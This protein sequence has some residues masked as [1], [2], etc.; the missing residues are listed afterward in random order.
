ME[1]RDGTEAVAGA[2]IDT[3]GTFAAGV[4][5]DT[6]VDIYVDDQLIDTVPAGKGDVSYHCPTD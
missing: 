3:P 5:E 1:F 4:R 6:S 2:K